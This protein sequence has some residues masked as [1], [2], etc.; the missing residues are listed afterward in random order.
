MPLAYGAGLLIL[1]PRRQAFCW[2]SDGVQRSETCSRSEGALRCVG[3]A[4]SHR[5]WSVV[6]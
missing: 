3:R 1:V 2:R 5:F 6:K 4:V